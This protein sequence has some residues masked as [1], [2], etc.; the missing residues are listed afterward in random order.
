[1]LHLLILSGALAER[2]KYPADS[3]LVELRAEADKAG[4]VACETGNHQ[5]CRDY[6]RYWKTNS[7]N[8]TD[9]NF[10]R[11]APFKKM[12]I[13]S[14]GQTF[15]GGGRFSTSI[16]DADAVNGQHDAVASHMAF[17]R[18]LKYRFDVNVDFL[19]NT[20]SSQYN[21]LLQSWYP[22][23]TQFKFGTVNSSLT[24][25][26]A[27]QNLLNSAVRLRRRIGDYGGVFFIRADL[28]LKPQFFQAFTFYDRVTFP[29]IVERRNS[30]L[31]TNKRPQ[32]G[33]VLLY[34]PNRYFGLMYA[35][36]GFRLFHD[37]Y[38]HYNVSQMGFM[39]NTYHECN[40]QEAANPLYR[41]VNR[42]I[43]N[44]TADIGRTYDDFDGV[45]EDDDAYIKLE[46]SNVPHEKDS[47]SIAEQIGVGIA[48]AALFAAA[49]A[50]YRHRYRSRDTVK[51]LISN[52][53]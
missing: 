10:S 2:P 42:P 12:L 40:S 33:D 11:D 52:P 27:Y 46:I 19:V 21:N 6:E 4:L 49:I 17:S 8:F 5:V 35:R 44:D 3:D 53:N 14:V 34:V 26:F 29:F 50:T 39:L 32:I 22:T 18:Y 13:I 23:G 1:M 37:A 31:L 15:R 16:G 43:S 36:D 38:N 30:K 47:F 20:Y 24:A 28:Y 41:M 7:Y 48:A 51:S 9:L 25:E 45:W